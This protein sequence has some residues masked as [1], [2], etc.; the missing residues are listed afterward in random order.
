M[1]MYYRV[2]GGVIALFQLSILCISLHLCGWRTSR[3]LLCFLITHLANICRPSDK[4]ILL[5]TDVFPSVV[6][7]T[8]RRKN[9]F[10]FFFFFFFFSQLW[11]LFGF[12]DPCAIV[13]DHCVSPS[14]MRPQNTTI[15]ARRRRPL[16]ISGI[17]RG[18]ILYDTSSLVS[19]IQRS[20][21][22]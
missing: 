2:G 13:L 21:S 4:E 1:Y 19:L 22:E 15:T 7:T 5:P 3:Y 11:Y 18:A 6:W 14:L 10:F 17:R 9:I 16:L 8:K 20:P 12:Y